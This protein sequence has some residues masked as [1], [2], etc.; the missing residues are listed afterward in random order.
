MQTEDEAASAAG[1]VPEPPAPQGART[2]EADAGDAGGG[3]AG[4]AMHA[5]PLVQDFLLDPTSWPIWAAVALMRSVME[6]APSIERLFYRSKPT[7]GFSGSEIQDVGI[8]EGAIHLVLSAP[9]L[10]APGSALPLPDVARIVADTYRPDGGAIAYWLD[11]MVDRLMQVVEAAE[12]R[13]NAAFALATGA[14]LQVVDSVLKLAGMSAPLRA[15]PGGVLQDSFSEEGEPVPGLARMFAG[16]A[17]AAGLQSLVSGFTDLPAAVE[18]F[19]GV[20]MPVINPLRVGAVL[21]G[22]AVGRECTVGAAGVNVILDGTED[23]DAVEWVRDPARGLSLANLCEA[24]VGARVP[25]VFLFV[26]LAPQFI[27]QAELGGDTA[28]GRAPLLGSA[29]EAMRVP[30]EPVT[31]GN[32]PF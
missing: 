23:P 13:T 10:A 3:A 27:P 6:Q 9:G 1:D 19:I 15:K 17:T 30:I 26:E 11:G 28:F 4:E 24:Y 32:W 20:D 22:Q 8:A 14:D 16:Q 2:T 25:R 5:N 31:D 12:A 7:L 29:D 18:E 21:G